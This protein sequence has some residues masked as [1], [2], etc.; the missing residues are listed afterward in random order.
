MRDR[1]IV[2]QI[3]QEDLVSLPC[4]FVRYELGVDEINS[5]DITEEDDG[6][7]LAG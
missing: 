2:E 7:L 6:I 1:V 3:G 4:P 5:K